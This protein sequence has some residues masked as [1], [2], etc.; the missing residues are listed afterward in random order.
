MCYHKF[1]QVPGT[2][3]DPPCLWRSW[4]WPGSFAEPPNIH[5]TNLTIC[6]SEHTSTRR[7]SNFNHKHVAI[8]AIPPS[9]IYIYMHIYIYNHLYIFAIIFV[10]LKVAAG[11][12]L[13]LWNPESISICG[14]CQYPWNFHRNIWNMLLDAV[15]ASTQ[16]MHAN[17][18]QPLPIALLAHESSPFTRAPDSF[19][20]HGENGPLPRW[21]STW[22]Q[23]ERKSSD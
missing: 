10:F 9:T 19:Q 13:D 17:W 14:D 16:L 21:L 7:F 15:R 20:H 18:M 5:C 6:V 1:I 11:M 12:G 8:P 2:K 4:I 23:D 22:R 3:T